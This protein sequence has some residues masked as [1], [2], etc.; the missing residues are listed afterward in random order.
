MKAINDAFLT[1][2]CNWQTNTI[3]VTITPVLLDYLFSNNGRDLS[4]AA[5]A[6]LIEPQLINIAYVI[7]NTT[8]KYQP[9]IREWTYLSPNQKTWA[10]FKM[11]FFQAHLE[12]KEAGGLQ[13]CETQFNSA[14]LMFRKLLMGSNLS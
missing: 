8:G 3:D 7:L 13:L 6:N 1:A 12:L 9:Y 14:N 11:H 5:R 4:V 2:L 10:N